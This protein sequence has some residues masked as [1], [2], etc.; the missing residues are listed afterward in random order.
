MR[1][2][3]RTL[4]ALAVAGRLSAPAP[5][6][7][8]VP[9]NQNPTN[10][11]GEA[12]NRP[13]EKSATEMRRESIQKA[14]D[15]AQNPPKA[16]DA[17]IGHNQPP[18]KTPKEKAAKPGEAPQDG[19][20]DQQKGPQ[21]GDKGRFAPK[22]GQP[23]E[24]TG[25]KPGEVQ[26]PATSRTAP[27]QLPDNAPYRD[28]P[29]RMAEHAKA[30]WAA[31]PEPVRA[32]VHRMAKETEAMYRAYRPDHDEMNKIRH[33][34]QMATQHGTTLE[35]ALTNYTTMEQKLRTDVIG[36]L[37][38]IVNNLGIRRGDG[39]PVTLRDIAYHIATQSPEQLQSMQSR[40]AQQASSHQI[41]SLHEEIAGLKNVVQQM[42]HATQFTYT[43]SAVDQF[44]DQPGHERFDELG[45]LIEQELSYGYDLPQAYA[46][47]S[48]LR[49]ASTTHAAQ[50]RDPPAQT[51][52]DKSISGAPDASVING[53]RP[54]RKGDKPVGRRDAIQNAIRRVNGGL[55]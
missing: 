7:A 14:F 46:R 36:G 37:D 24:K 50:T 9:V 2:V 28:P 43:R 42:H 40:N 49:P 54:T 47:A 41:G 21:R 32:E 13:P 25:L 44:A 27:R 52:A 31:A 39:S 3:T 5:A 26:D 15:R 19:P 34:H 17:K 33:F 22:S 45:D 20:Q 4:L 8:E 55:A 10:I 1:A 6:A 53:A 12:S 38:I 30:E 18:E 11:P 48:M 23:D 29:P 16:A 51:R 35:R